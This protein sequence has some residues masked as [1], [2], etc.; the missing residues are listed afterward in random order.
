MFY[1]YYHT[2]LIKKSY[3]KMRILK[4]GGSSVGT[5]ARISNVINIL[6]EY[7]DKKI[8]FGV[9]FSAFQTITDKLIE[10]SQKAVEK[11][12]SYKY[13]LAQ[14]KQIHVDAVADLL[15]KKNDK[16]SLVGKVTALLSE[17]EEILHGIFLV[18]TNSAYT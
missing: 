1:F 17:L 11:T 15:S 10:V 9:V 8:K 12:G 6:T 3:K 18:K 5:P 4:F 16:E 13:D 2:A 7:R 14:I